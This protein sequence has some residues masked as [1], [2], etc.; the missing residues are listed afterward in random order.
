MWTQLTKRQELPRWFWPVMSTVA[1]AFLLSISLSWVQWKLQYGFQ[2]PVMWDG[3][4][5]RCFDNAQPFMPFAAF[6]H[7][8]FCSGTGPFIRFVSSRQSELC[9]RLCLYGG[10]VF[11]WLASRTMSG[12]W[13]AGIAAGYIATSALLFALDKQ[14]SPASLGILAVALS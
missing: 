1:S 11:V 14:V 3:G 12:W 7:S 6:L 8:I 2:E 5:Q 4:S 9:A 13:A 10:V